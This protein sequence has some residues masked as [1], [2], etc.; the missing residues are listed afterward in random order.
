M[1]KEVSRVSLQID[2]LGDTKLVKSV[3]AEKPLSAGGRVTV[4]V[5]TVSRASNEPSQRLK[6]W[7]A[8]AKIIWGWLT[9]VDS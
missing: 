6:T 7:D 9:Y 2:I 8:D 1:Y 3:R 4:V 5:S